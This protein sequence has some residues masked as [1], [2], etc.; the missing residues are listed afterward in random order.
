MELRTTG[1]GRSQASSTDP[2]IRP[3]SKIQPDTSAEVFRWVAGKRRLDAGGA[4]MHKLGPLTSEL[5][6]VLSAENPAAFIHRFPERHQNRV[7]PRRGV[8]KGQ[9]AVKAKAEA[10][11]WVWGVDF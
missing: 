1:R 8:P 5:C 6:V 9:L 7:R 10:L 2:S 4:G 3:R 11:T